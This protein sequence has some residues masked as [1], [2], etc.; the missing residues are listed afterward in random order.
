MIQALLYLQVAQ[1]RNRCLAQG[2]RL[3][4]PRYL[5]GAVLGVGYFYFFLFRGFVIRGPGP[6][7]AGTPAPGLGAE[8]MPLV[9]LAG[10]ILVLV[11]ALANWLLPTKRTALDFSEAEAAF[12]FPAPISRTALLNYRLLRAQLPL[13]FTA[14][15]MM[16]ITGRMTSAG[17]IWTQGISWW[18]AIIA[19]EWHRIGASFT[20]TRLMDRGLTTSRRRLR[21]L[22]MV[23]LVL[24]AGYFWA[25]AT[26]E[27]PSPKD[28]ENE[29]ALAAYA[30]RLGNHGPW[31]WLLGPFRLLV[32]P[33]LAPSVSAFFLAVM[34]VLGILAL[35]HVW[36]LRSQVAFE[37]A[38][39][40]RAEERARLLAA[41]RSGNWHLA[42]PARRG[43]EPFPLSIP[44]PRLLAFLWK[45]LIAAAGP[46][47]P[48][49]WLAI[50]GL[51]FMAAIV[52]RGFF[53]DSAGLQV[54][55]TLPVAILPVLF[56]VGPQVLGVDLRQDLALAENLKTYPLPGWQ[57]VLGELLAPA[58]ILT[59]VD[60]FLVALAVLA[61]PTPKAHPDWL[62]TH[63]LA[64]G[65]C[66]FLAAPGLNWIALLL[67]NAAALLLPA[68]SPVGH[69]GSRGFEATGRNILFM[70]GQLLGLS[71]ALLPAG[72]VA[73]AVFFGLHLAL[74]WMVA[75]PMAVL[76]ALGILLAEVYAGAR[77]LGDYFERMDITA[78]LAPRP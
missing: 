69:D 54:L 48:R 9:E 37:E 15:I 36:I 10:A 55:G 60:G 31:F 61:F 70:I 29:K 1:F 14:L 42:R 39:L 76:C 46:F 75:A 8:W 27:L 20:L 28:L 50:G 77:M 33:M 56:L 34:P 12:L 32:R 45:N 38:S 7:A 23:A 49:L 72:L 52:A 13:L 35:L 3:R 66:V 62:W 2:R 44:G 21:I 4:Q 26:F 40:S 71:L 47:S 25:Q 64:L 6:G 67:H 68:W 11:F 41:T 53:P 65:L 24:I 5:I 17:H 58:V 57:I 78:E 16:L 43:R 30:S 19:L 18:L 63:R 74:P 59:A 73:T 51:L 22:A